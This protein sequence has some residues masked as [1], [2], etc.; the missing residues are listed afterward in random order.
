M[1]LDALVDSYLSHLRVERALSPHTVAA[2][3]RDLSKFV[4]FA[5]KQQVREL[6]QLDLGLI[7]SWLGSLSRE[8]LGPRSSARHLSALRGLMKFLVRE[9][10]LS[11]DPTR[12][13][14][15]PRIGRRLPRVL[16]EEAM[17]RLIETP[18]ISKLRGLRDRA[19]LSVAYAAGLR[20]SELINLA[21]KF[22]TCL[23]RAPTTLAVSLP[24]T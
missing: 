24:G 13:A 4:A 12:L 21:G 19:M 23:T 15:R 20:V 16:D 1:A 8:G 6:S 14:P 10:E 11:D 5:E 9:G 17:L 3:G 22:L 18:D 2:Y 7:S